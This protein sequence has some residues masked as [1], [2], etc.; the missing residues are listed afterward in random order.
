MV[1][2]LNVFLGVGLALL[3]LAFYF[4]IVEAFLPIIDVLLNDLLN[5][6]SFKLLRLS[7]YLCIP[8]NLELFYISTILTPI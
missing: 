7:F 1:L 3:S 5:S 6:L 4:C 8:T 2:I